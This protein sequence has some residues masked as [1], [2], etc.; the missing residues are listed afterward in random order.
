VLLDRAVVEG[1]IR[2]DADF[3]AILD[4]I[5]GPILNCLLM[6]HAPAS[7]TFAETL[8]TEVLTGLRQ[9]SSSPAR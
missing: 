8:L 1:S 4:L 9:S 6:G 3:D 7:E 5:Y 2:E